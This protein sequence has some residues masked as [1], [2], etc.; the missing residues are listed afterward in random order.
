MWISRKKLNKLVESNTEL[1]TRVESLEESISALKK[2]VDNIASETRGIE[3]GKAQPVYSHF[4]WVD[5]IKDTIGLSEVVQ[6]ILTH[7]KLE[8]NVTPSTPIETKL[9]KTKPIKKVKP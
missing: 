9:I 6:H 7:L 5:H 2:K 3:Y 1:L 8:L 4:G